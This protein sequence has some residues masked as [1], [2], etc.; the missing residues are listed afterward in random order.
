MQM[1]DK[2]FNDLSLRDQFIILNLNRSSYYYKTIE[3]KNL[4]QNIANAI[5]ELWLK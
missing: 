2:N 5:S 1:I 4:D 3:T